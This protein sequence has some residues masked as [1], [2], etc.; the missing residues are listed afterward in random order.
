MKRLGA[1]ISLAMLMVML[2]CPFTYAAGLELVSMSPKDGQTGL[3]PMGVAIKMTFN[4]NMTDKAAQEENKDCFTITDAEGNKMQYMPVYDA[5]KYP[6]DVWLIIKDNLISNNEYKVV[7]S[8]DLVSSEGDHLGADLIS[9]FKIRNT[10]TDT[11]VNMVMMVGMMGGM[12]FFSSMDAKRKMKKEAEE[13]IEEEH[14]NPYK[15]AKE[16]GISVDDAVKQVE[17]EKAKA[18]KKK[19]KKQK[20]EAKHHQIQDGVKRVSKKKPIAAVGGMTPQFVLE[21]NQKKR[22]TQEQAKQERLEK[23][24]ARQEKSKKK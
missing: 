7:V 22:E 20:A 24:L 23:E 21:R 19:A 17:K 2:A 6:N 1:I 3:Q 18:A 15:I 14:L 13:N 4:E 10:S 9:E 12:V 16:K 11:T 5:A 8:G